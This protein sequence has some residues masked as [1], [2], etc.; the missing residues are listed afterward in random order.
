M[1]VINPFSRIDL[2]QAQTMRNVREKT[3][4]TMDT[5]EVKSAYSAA[6]V[7]QEEIRKILQGQQKT[8]MDT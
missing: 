2:K 7:Y 6:K 5:P 4:P 1:A 8:G 3:R